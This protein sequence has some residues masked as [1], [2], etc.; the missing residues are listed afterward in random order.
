[1]TL[2]RGFK[3]V[4]SDEEWQRRHAGH[5]TTHVTRDIPTCGGIARQHWDRCEACKAARLTNVEHLD[6]DGNP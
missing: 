4:E 6:K 1:M 5:K 3:G 2:P